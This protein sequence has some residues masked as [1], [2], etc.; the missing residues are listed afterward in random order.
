MLLCLHGQKEV[1]HFFG[2]NFPLSLNRTILPNL[3]PKSCHHK[4]IRKEDISQADSTSQVQKAVMSFFDKA[5]MGHHAIFLS[6]FR[7]SLDISLSQDLLRRISET[8]QAS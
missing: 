7:F 4:K 2:K 5:L 8:L 6:E 1:S 3:L